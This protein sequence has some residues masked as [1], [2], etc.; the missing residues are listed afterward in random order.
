MNAPTF[1]LS[2]KEWRFF[3]EG[4]SKGVTGDL[5]PYAVQ[6]GREPRGQNEYL[7]VY[8]YG[9]GDSVNCIWAVRRTP[10]DGP[11]EG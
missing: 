7:L 4:Y 9:R 1:P 2:T 6:W 8:V 3:T 5:E 10:D 11:R